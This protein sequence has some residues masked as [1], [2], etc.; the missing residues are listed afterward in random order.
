M[1]Q[2]DIYRLDALSARYV[3]E[4]RFRFAVRAIAMIVAIFIY[5]SSCNVG[6]FAQNKENVVLHSVEYS[7]HMSY[8]ALHRSFRPTSYDKRS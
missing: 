6:S 4:E 3:Q 2:E 8:G 7:S 5:C 1:K